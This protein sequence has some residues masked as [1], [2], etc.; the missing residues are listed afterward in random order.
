MTAAAKDLCKDMD[1]RLEH[2]ATALRPSASGWRVE[3]EGKSAIEAR[4]LLCT[5]PLPQSLALLDAG[6]V[7]L[8]GSLRQGLEEVRY[9][10]CLVVMARLDRAPDLPDPGIVEPVEGP[11]LRVVDNVRKGVSALPAVTLQA[12]PAFSAHWLDGDRQQAAQL[13]LEA[14]RPFL[15]ARVEEWQMHAWRYS[16]VENPL[17]DLYAELP[18]RAP[19]LL[20]GDAFAGDR[21]EDALRSGLSAARR[22]HELAE[23]AAR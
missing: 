4:S 15:G 3:V 14:A 21:V 6:G 20:A 17:T 9:A 1:L 7:A 8:E 19:L 16:Q 12:T 5:A 11:L 13:L 18:G 23:E 22:L 10:P 2:K